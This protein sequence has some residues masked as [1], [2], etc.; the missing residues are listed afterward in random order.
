MNEALDLLKSLAIPALNVAAGLW[1][2]VK[3]YKLVT[4]NDMIYRLLALLS[5]EN[6]RALPADSDR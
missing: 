3:S 1:F 6:K 2:M 5:R 4:D